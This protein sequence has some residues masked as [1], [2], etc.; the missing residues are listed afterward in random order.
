MSEQA[1]NS[2]QPGRLQRALE[3]PFVIAIFGAV[4]SWFVPR[5]LEPLSSGISIPFDL[6]LAIAYLLL[7]AIL[8][9]SYNAVKKGLLPL[10]N[11]NVF[12]IVFGV[13]LLGLAYIV[14]IGPT[15]ICPRGYPLC[16]KV[17]TN[18]QWTPVIQEFDGV[19]MVLVP[20]GCFEMGSDQTRTCFDE[21]F[22]MDRFEVTNAQFAS[23]AG[24]ASNDSHWAEENRP[25]EQ[26]S[27]AEANDFCARRDAQLPSEAEWEYAARGPDNLLYPWGNA[28]DGTRVNFCDSNCEFDWQDT[29][30]DDGYPDTAPAGSYQTGASWVG[31]YDMSGNVW[32]WTD[33]HVLRGGSFGDSLER[34]NAVFRNEQESG[35]GSDDDGFRCVRAYTN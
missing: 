20:A 23:L 15:E 9:A 5:I 14:E 1:P 16:R 2:E 28:F 11:V 4:V 18:E 19:D 31:A 21:P 6:I 13:T 22:W 34:L 3:H 33:S 8:I 10:R 12:W 35:E 26:I 30:S 32:E 25:R 27:W 17:T 7:L 29:D 24:G